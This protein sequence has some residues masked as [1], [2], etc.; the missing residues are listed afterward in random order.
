MAALWRATAPDR[1]D[2]RLR[3]VRAPVVVVRGTHDAL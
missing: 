2:E 3:G 1:I